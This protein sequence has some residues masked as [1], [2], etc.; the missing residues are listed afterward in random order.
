MA[1]AA[2]GAVVVA[3]MALCVSWFV[4]KET[5]KQVQLTEAALN[6]AR[7]GA[8]A[9]NENSAKASAATDEALRIAREQL[10]LARRS[11]EATDR[12][13]IS[14]EQTRVVRDGQKRRLTTIVVLKNYGNTPAH[15]TMRTSIR[16]VPELPPSRP[17]PEVVISPQASKTVEI[18]ITGAAFD[19]AIERKSRFEV[20]VLVQY[21]GRGD[22]KYTLRYRGLVDPEELSAAILE[23]TD[24]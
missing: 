20:G 4:W 14:I 3:S 23:E 6:L 19:A 22:A 16:G 2:I 8:T 24:R 9:A 12:P 10:E 21:S 5:Q 7:D 15:C 1:V 18:G 17:L 13:D 11:W